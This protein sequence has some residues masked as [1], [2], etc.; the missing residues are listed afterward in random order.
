MGVREDLI[1]E[2]N[3]IIARLTV[4]EG[5]DEKKTL[6]RLEGIEASKVA[7]ASRFS[8]LTVSWTQDGAKQKVGPGAQMS[9]QEFT[10]AVK[11]LSRLVLEK[12]AI[13]M[14][15]PFEAMHVSNDFRRRQQARAAKMRHAY[16]RLAALREGVTG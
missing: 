4:E 6:D 9:P 13:R 7:G 5:E 11:A 10:N 12:A 1:T 2:Q 8:G 3:A 16:A 14:P 15:D